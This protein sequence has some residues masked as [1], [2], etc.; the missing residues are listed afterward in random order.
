[1]KLK[2]RKTDQALV[3]MQK[4]TSKITESPEKARDFLYKAGIVTKK[5]NLKKPYTMTGHKR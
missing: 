1:M 5:G 2:D 3:E 4:F